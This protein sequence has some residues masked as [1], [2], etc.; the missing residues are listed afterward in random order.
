MSAGHADH[1]TDERQR[2]GLSGAAWTAAPQ[3]WRDLWWLLNAPPFWPWQADDAADLF[4]LPLWTPAQ[5]PS[6]QAWLCAQAE[7]PDALLAAFYGALTPKGAV[8]VTDFYRHDTPPPRLGRMAEALFN[9][10]MQ[11]SPAVQWLASGVPIFATPA[12][13]APKSAGKQQLGELDALWRDGDGQLVHAELAVKFYGLSAATASGTAD[14]PSRAR[15]AIG[16]DGVENWQHKL[17][18]LCHR[19]LCHPLPEPWD[20][21]PVQRL[22]HVRGRWFL[23]APVT[24]ISAWACTLGHKTADDWA[25]VW[26]PGPWQSPVA[27]NT[28]RFGPRLSRAGLAALQ[29]PPHVR[30]RLLRRVEWLG[31]VAQADDQR[32]CAPDARGRLPVSD[33]LAMAPPH[34][35]QRVQML[36]VFAQLPTGQ[37]LEQW[38]AWVDAEA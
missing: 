5:A 33:L 15:A 27:S 37:W 11:N 34:A 23:H 26:G 7:H 29:L 1:D 31:P 36:G 9:F 10:F 28:Q 16:P 17:E 8:A 6:V 35:L 13:G 20:T 30:V 12:A 19:Q 3:A 2:S 18:K 32:L 14:L 4:C 24:S 25:R 38:R 22:A 21:E